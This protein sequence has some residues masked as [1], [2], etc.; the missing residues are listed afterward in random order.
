MPA[1]SHE[2]TT[3]NELMERIGNEPSL[4][5]AQRS[6]LRSAIRRFAELCGRH[7][8]EI[9][10]DPAVIRQWIGCASWQMAGL[11]KHGWA[12]ITS[13]LTRA[14]KIAGIKVHRRRRNYKLAADWE[15]LLGPMARRDRDELHRF[16][17]WCSVHGIPPVE[18]NV[19]VFERYLAYLERE[20]IQLKPRERW[21]VARR[22]WNRIC[23]AVP[24]PGFPAIPNNEPEGWRGLKWSAFP[25]S[26]IAEI[27]M[28]KIAV[29]TADPF[30]E[31]ERR[32]IKKVTLAGYLN[33]LRWHL[34]R[35]V[36]DGV[37]VE[38]F[39]SLAAC[40]DVDLV[41]RG[42][43]LRL[44]NKELDDTTKPGLS[45]MMTAIISV[46][47]F[48]GVSD[49]HYRQLKRLADR[50]RHRPEGMTERNKERLAQFNDEAA[51]R[52]LVNLPFRMANELADVTQPTVRQAQRMQMAAMLAVLTRL[53]LRIKNV[54][55]LDL[56]VHIKRPAG[57]A[58]GRWLVH[59]VEGEVKNKVAIDG[60]FNE[61]VSALLQ[62]YVAVF[63][64]ILLKKP[65]SKLFVSQN[66]T[67]K[68]PH[69]LSRQFRSLI[70][71]ELGLAMNAH[72]MRHWAGFVY[73]ENHPGDYETVRQLLGHKNITTTIRLYTGA[74]TK[75]A[76][77]LY[78]QIIA[79]HLDPAPLKFVKAPPL[80][81]E[82][83]AAHGLNPEDVL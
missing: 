61:T 51:R 39:T 60:L 49:E 3:L 40:I 80:D 56:D 24:G 10:A 27:E 57:G 73:L 74:E 22:A 53:P 47:R 7:P 8:S 79:A 52:A 2:T 42:L 23:A 16:A 36:E 67:G 68:D 31:D 33:N 59:F 70:K 35:L 13:R 45:A 29:T 14:M 30:A 62:R 58:D 66:G 64:P 69:T 63:R 55:A 77:H 43:T 71:R 78:D 75:S 44:G 18:V 21:H 82:A 48:V 81:T 46:A 41:K 26:L 50:V 38:H 15:L 5:P 9:I 1:P 6:E 4:S 32:A 34:S 12:N 83:R 54:A 28:Y 65:S 17:G 72:L 76:H 37:P 19:E 20:M 25:N 11:S